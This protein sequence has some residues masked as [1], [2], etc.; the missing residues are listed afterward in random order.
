MR[1][2]LSGSS[3]FI[4]GALRLFL[5]EKGNE[6][7]PLVRSCSPIS[8]SVCWDPLKGRVRK[9]DFEDFDVVIH[10]AG[11]SLAT[12]RWTR[13]KKQRLLNSRCRDSWLLSQILLRLCRPPPLVLCAS[14]IGFYG[15]RGQECLTEK[16]LKGEGFL[17]DLCEQWESAMQGI[18][19]RGARVVHPRFGLVLDPSGG[20]LRQIFLLS[21]LGLGGRLGDGQQI[22]RWIALQDV[23]EGINHVISTPQLEGPVNFVAP[24]PVSQAEFMRVIQDKRGRKMGLPISAWML[25]ILLGEKA[26]AM[27]LSSAHVIPQ[28]LLESGYRFQCPHLDQLILKKR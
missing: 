10:L 17:P 13:R 1:I 14:A 26:E 23:L 21:Q 27:L 19:K 4:G 22:I 6:V 3:G 2:L 11:E 16:S 25:R 8:R 9:E 28:K 7:V 24:A 15:D 12:G 18:E 20:Y 5:T